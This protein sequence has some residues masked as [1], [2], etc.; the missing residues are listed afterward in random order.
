MSGW[1]KLHT[2]RCECGAL[3]CTATIEMLWEEED[4]VDHNG[5]WAIHPEH[6]PRGARSWQVVEANERFVVV[7]V[8]ELHDPL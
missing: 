7:D 1:F 2:R 3:D 8:K 4:A 5:Y 6:E